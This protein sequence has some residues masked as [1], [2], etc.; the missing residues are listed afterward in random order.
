MAVGHGAAEGFGR[1]PPT[2]KPARPFRPK[3]AASWGGRHHF[4]YFGEGGEPAGRTTGSCCRRDQET[5]ASRAV[6]LRI[7]RVEPSKRISCFFLRSLNSR[8]T[9]SRDA[10]IIC[11]LS[12]CVSPELTRTSLPL[13]VGGVQDSS[14]LAS[15]P[16]PPPTY[17][18]NRAPCLDY[19]NV[20]LARNHCAWRS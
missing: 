12:S 1:Q 18:P 2:G 13:P 8:V 6:R 7:T 9:V 5:I 19:T 15:F 20:H 11:A 3:T 4:A 16:V 10:P 17:F 14:S